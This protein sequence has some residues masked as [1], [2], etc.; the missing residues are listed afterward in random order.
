MNSASKENT[1]EENSAMSSLNYISAGNRVEMR[2][3]L[4]RQH[5]PLSN[6]QQAFGQIFED[7]VN[8]FPPFSDICYLSYLRIFC[9]LWPPAAPA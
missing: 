8:V 2:V 5:Q 4:L 9:W 1:E 3:A 6:V 7:D